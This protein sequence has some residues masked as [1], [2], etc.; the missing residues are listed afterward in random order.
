[1]IVR[2]RAVDTASKNELYVG[3]VT[4]AVVSHLKSPGVVD[5]KTIGP[6]QIHVMRSVPCEGIISDDAACAR[7]IFYRCIASHVSEHGSRDQNIISIYPQSARHRP[8]LVGRTA[9]FGQSRVTQARPLEYQT[10]KPDSVANYIDGHDRVPRQ[11]GHNRKMKKGA[12]RFIGKAGRGGGIQALCPQYDRTQY[13]DGCCDQITAWGDRHGP[14]RLRRIQ[15]GLEGWS[16]V[17]HIARQ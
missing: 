12:T 2:D 9:F 17:A 13:P 3:I 10:I 1:M 16:R 8:L 6:T 11:G 4:K 15:T 7:S 5:S 14:A